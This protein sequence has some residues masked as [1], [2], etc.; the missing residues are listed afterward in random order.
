MTTALRPVSFRCS[1]ESSCLL[2]VPKLSLSCFGDSA[3]GTNVACPF[4]QVYLYVH[5]PI[6]VL[7][8]KTPSQTLSLSYWVSGSTCR[9]PSVP[10][11]VDLQCDMPLLVTVLSLSLWP[12]LFVPDELLPLAFCMVCS[13]GRGDIL[14]PI[15]IMLA[16]FI[17]SQ[18]FSDFPKWAQ[19]RVFLPLSV[20][21]H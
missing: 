18:T 17:W 5:R 7:P 16:L 19:T 1:S 2:A 11:S 13:V 4:T 8:C 6:L 3:V 12:K 9:S 20:H 15:T 10:L 21:H 14:S